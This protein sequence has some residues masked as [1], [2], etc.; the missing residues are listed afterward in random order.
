MKTIFN[1]ENKSTLTYR[2]SLAP[3]M[4]I[5]EQE[6]A[7]QYLAEYIKFQ[8]RKRDE[9]PEEKSAHTAEQMCK[10]NLGYYA[11]YYSNETRERVEKLF[12]CSH[13]IFGGIA[14]NGNPSPETAIRKGFET[15]QSKEN[16]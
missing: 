8:Q 10:I 5:T 15:A 16:N 1:P 13:P 3:A 2:E 4:E 11:G 14:Q 7:D 9:R 12:K 6:D